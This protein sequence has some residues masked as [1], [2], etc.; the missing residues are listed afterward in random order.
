MRRAA[1]WRVT[2]ALSLDATDRFPWLR[3]ESGVY[4]SGLLSHG[5]PGVAPRDSERHAIGIGWQG[6]TPGPSRERSAHRARCWSSTVRAGV[7]SRLFLPTNIA[8]RPLATHCIKR[9]LRSAP[10]DGILAFGKRHGRPRGRPVERQARAVATSRK[11]SFG[12]CQ[13]GSA[14]RKLAPCGRSLARSRLVSCASGSARI[15]A[16]KRR[17]NRLARTGSPRSCTSEY[18]WLP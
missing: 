18:P 6:C 8:R 17:L 12:R 10:G 7:N 15:V 11:S 9:Q 3:S 16:Y 13:L 1:E 2:A 5:R 4:T 14:R